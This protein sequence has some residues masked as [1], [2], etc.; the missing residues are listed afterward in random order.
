MTWSFGRPDVRCNTPKLMTEDEDLEVL[1]VLV[2]AV[3]AAADYDGD[4]GTGDEV[5]EGQHRPIV[6]G[7][8]DRESGFPTPTGCRVH[9]EGDLFAASRYAAL[10]ASSSS[11]EGFLTARP[12]AS[13]TGAIALAT[14][15][16][17]FGARRSKTVL[18]GMKLP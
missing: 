2:A 11:S 9:A 14:A 1:G 3:L 4:E 8:S 10:T 12:A 5:E 6:P 18:Q 16:I 15:S 17:A 7:R 13:S